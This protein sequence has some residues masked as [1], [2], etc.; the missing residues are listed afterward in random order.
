M[1]LRMVNNLI[2]NSEDEISDR[3]DRNR[4]PAILQQTQTVMMT[5]EVSNTIENNF[6]V[7]QIAEEKEK[8]AFLAQQPN[9]AE[10]VYVLE[11]PPSERANRYY[12][13]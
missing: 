8:K 6:N 5:G 12:R 1:R 11:A 4:L 9:R 2:Q 7:N 10:L 13:P 3:N